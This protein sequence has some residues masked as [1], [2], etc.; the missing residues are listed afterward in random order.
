M[1]SGLLGAAWRNGGGHRS[2]AGLGPLERA[3]MDVVWQGSQVSVRDVQ[4]RLGRA[5]A[6]TTV[7]TTLDR[8]FKKGLVRRARSGRA[9][10]YSSAL[11]REEVEAKLTAGLLREVMSSRVFGST[12]FLSNLVDAVAD[13]DDRLLDEL[14]R[15]V[16]DRRR[17]GKSESV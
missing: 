1:L 11:T 7:M 9:F 16:R 14:E 17:R 8:L 4:T 5:V 13:S 2:R 6:Y 12:P 10:V 3:V 15:L